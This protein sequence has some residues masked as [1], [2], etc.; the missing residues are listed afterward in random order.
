MTKDTKHTSDEKFEDKDKLDEE[1]ENIAKE[2]EKECCDE[3]TENS[4]K[5]LRMILNLL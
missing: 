3:D 1:L 2:A 4:E 5:K